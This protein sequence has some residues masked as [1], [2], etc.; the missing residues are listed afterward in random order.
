MADLDTPRNAIEFLLTGVDSDKFAIDPNGVLSAEQALD[1]ESPA[2]ENGD[3]IFDLI[4]VANDA[5]GN[6]SDTVP[7]QVRLSNQW[8]TEGCDEG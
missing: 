4:L 8:G 7:I 3:A 6:T 5:A 1:F 2:D